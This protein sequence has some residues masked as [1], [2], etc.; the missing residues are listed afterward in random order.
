MLW[1]W[2]LIINILFTYYLNLIQNYKL[3]RK[4]KFEF[5]LKITAYIKLRFKLK[6]C[7]LYKKNKHNIQIK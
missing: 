4:Y 7:G 5:E 3:I 1:L 6:Y 2:I